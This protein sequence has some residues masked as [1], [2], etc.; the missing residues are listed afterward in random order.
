MYSHS[1]LV[2]DVDALAVSHKSLKAEAARLT[3]ER[4]RWKEW[5]ERALQQEPELP[6]EPPE[7]HVRVRGVVAL[8]RNGK[9]RI[10]G[11]SGATPLT[12]FD[13]MLERAACSMVNGAVEV[14]FFTV[15]V[16]LPRQPQTVQGHVV[17]TEE[18]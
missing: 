9:Y 12:S 6:T 18:A 7:G 13:E 10:E 3:E 2:T 1:D 14:T 5:L 16:P 8:S 17:Q 4:D 15:D 11:W